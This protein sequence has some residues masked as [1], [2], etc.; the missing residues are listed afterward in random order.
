MSFAIFDEEFYLANNPD[1]QAAVKAGSFK[2]GLEHFQQY[3]IKEHRVSVSAFYEETDYLQKYPDVAT[4]V[5][6]GA[7]NSG[8]QHYIE[9]GETEGRQAN[10]LFDEQFYLQ[11]N[12]DV[13]L[14][15]KNGAF[16]SGLQHYIEYG[17]SEG[18]QVSVLFD[19][20]FY[21]RKN[22]DVAAAVK[23]GSVNSGL[24]HYLQFGQA[25]G[26]S[27]TNFNELGY[28]IGELRY[29]FVQ[30]NSDVA[31]AVKNGIFGSALEHYIKYGQ[32]EDRGGIFT[33]TRGN[34][35]VTGFGQIDTIYGIA[36]SP[37]LASYYLGG[38]KSLNFDSFGVNE[39]DVLVGGSG[40]DRFVL[41]VLLPDRYPL[42]RSFY[43]GGGNAD[44]ATIENFE[45]GKD[46][47]VLAGSTY[48]YLFSKS[49][50]DLNI[51]LSASNI[52][53]FR[54]PLSSPDLVAT[55]KGVTSVSQ[56]ENSIQFTGGFLS[57]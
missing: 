50:G 11:R 53:G 4:A 2:S 10:G 13:A 32:F 24:A 56:I 30:G 54:E 5:K 8:L 28:T 27:G 15:V 57:A 39:V 43:I 41:G 26:R 33:G 14:A 35:T 9:Y 52:Y 20:E 3:G 44:F 46:T 18:R 55:V 17:K 40:K 38:G 19:E 23:A 51:F 45:L 42:P 1:V 21:L 31:I 25:E 49:D 22:P 48:N 34:D 37:G 29:P 7:F 12:P 36:R 6:N 47:L 16:H